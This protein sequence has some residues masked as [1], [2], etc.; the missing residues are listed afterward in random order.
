MHLAQHMLSLV[1][2]GAAVE[3]LIL[4]G[5]RLGLALECLPEVRSA[6]APFTIMLK[7]R[8]MASPALDDLERVIE[9][10]CTNRRLRFTG[11]PLAPAGLS[12]LQADAGAIEGAAIVWL[13]SPSQ[14]RQALR[15]IRA[16][17]TERFRNR[18]LHHELF[19]SIR[20]D[21]GWRDTTADGLPPGALELPLVE[22][23]LFAMLRSWSIQ[24]GLNLFGVHHFIGFRAADLPCRLAPHLGV[25]TCHGESE[26]AAIAGGRALQRVWLRS[27]AM[28]LSFQVFAASAAYAYQGT[29]GIDAKLQCMLRDGW[30][31]LCPNTRP[32]II[33][34]MGHAAA[35]SVRTVRAVEGV[36]SRSDRATGNYTPPPEAP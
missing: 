8:P 24:H 16:A 17:E 23:P 25:I 3:N 27:A 20:F 2:I 19:S 35:P 5:R 10:R 22:R 4:R 6:D 33:F 36:P 29:R 12:Q 13:D 14:R 9:D 11:P 21:L 7:C 32:I 15:L 31:E 18:H 34:R 28:G 1:S 26:A 30:A